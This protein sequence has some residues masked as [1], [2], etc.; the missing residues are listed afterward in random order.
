MPLCYP[1]F[2]RYQ[3]YFSVPLIAAQGDALRYRYYCITNA[4][5]VF[6]AVILNNASDYRAKGDARQDGFR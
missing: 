5:I 2:C 3:P 6:N 1:N 4:Q